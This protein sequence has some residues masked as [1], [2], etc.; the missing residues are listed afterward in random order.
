AQ[1]KYCDEILQRISKYQNAY[2]FVEPVDPVK[3]NIPD[4]PEKIK[5]PMD[6]STVRWKIKSNMYTSVSELKKDMEL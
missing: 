1:I 2:P 5:N 4:Y 6:I 3:L